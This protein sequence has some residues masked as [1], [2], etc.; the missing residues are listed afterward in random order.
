MLT[1]YKGDYSLT[2]ATLQFTQGKKNIL[3]LV[4]L[5]LH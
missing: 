2:A 4:F 1:A 5:H 3:A